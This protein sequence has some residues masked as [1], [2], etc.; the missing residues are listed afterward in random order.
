V[1]LEISPK[2]ADPAR[3]DSRGGRRVCGAR[4]RA[5]LSREP[6]ARAFRHAAATAATGSVAVRGA[7]PRSVAL[8]W[9]PSPVTTG[10]AGP[11]FADT[12]RASRV[13]GQRFSALACGSR[14]KWAF[15]R[16][17]RRRSSSS[18]G[19]DIL[20]CSRAGCLICSSGVCRG[21]FPTIISDSPRRSARVGRRRR[22]LKGVGADGLR[23]A[24]PVVRLRWL[25]RRS[26]EEVGWPSRFRRRSKSSSGAATP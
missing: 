16:G 18:L 26:K 19:R 24:S 25:R 1:P 15:L 4:R 5:H 6:S 3:S 22:M 2:Q 7:C 13:P 12:Q 17:R 8:C 10:R 20:V 9:S 21:G 11:R 23:N 14:P